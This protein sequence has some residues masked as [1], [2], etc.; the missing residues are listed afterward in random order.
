MKTREGYA[1]QT[2]SIIIGI[3]SKALK[4]SVYPYKY[5]KENPMHYVELMKD[6]SR[7]PTREDLKIQ[8]KENLRRINSVLNED[9]PFY[10]PFHIGLHCGLR[11]GRNFTPVFG[12][13]ASIFF[14]YIP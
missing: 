4:H 8:S 2:L 1:R 11:V 9:H 6:K 12:V 13:M 10:L 3:L 14:R 5:I 7:K